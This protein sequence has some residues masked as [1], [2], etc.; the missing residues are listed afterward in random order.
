MC[1]CFSVGCSLQLSLLLEPGDMNATTTLTSDAS[2]CFVVLL[3]D[4]AH[5]L[6]ALGVARSQLLAMEIL[7]SSVKMDVT[8]IVDEG[9]IASRDDE[10]GHDTGVVGLFI[11][12]RRNRNHR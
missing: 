5:Q 4:T 7:V 8:S 1:D 6:G 10:D 9:A 2:L 3:A 11:V 12:R